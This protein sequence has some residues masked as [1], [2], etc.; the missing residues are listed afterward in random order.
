MI[1]TPQ[2]IVWVKAAYSTERAAFLRASAESGVLPEHIQEQYHNSAVRPMDTTTWRR[3]ENSDS[4]SCTSPSK[5][6]DNVSDMIDTFNTGRVIA[7]VVLHY[8]FQKYWLVAGNQQLQVCRASGIIPKVV[9]IR[10]K[11]R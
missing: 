9:F 2:K 8:G 5:V 1:L 4:W 3:L 11:D 10:T 6:R 7:P